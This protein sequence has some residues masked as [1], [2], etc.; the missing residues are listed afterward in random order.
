MQ[1]NRSLRSS[2]HV[3]CLAL[4]LFAGSQSARAATLVWT[5]VAG[6]A[7][8]NAANWSPNQ[9]PL[10]ADQAFIT[11][12]GSYIV[13]LAVNSAATV[14]VGGSGGTPILQQTAGTLSLGPASRIR[15]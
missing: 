3:L 13:T 15:F 5:N 12:A 1:S 6:G 9:V 14:T 2:L 10:T 4:A 8:T 11:N 7:W